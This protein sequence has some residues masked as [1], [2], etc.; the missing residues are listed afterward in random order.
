MAPT[1][2]TPD[3]SL[4]RRQMLTSLGLGAASAA[5]ITTSFSP[6]AAAQSRPTSQPV[7]DASAT[8][9]DP[10]TS[11]YVLPKLAYG[12]ADLEPHIDA[13]TMELHHSK[14]HAGYVRGLNAALAALTE[15]RDGRRETSEVKRW[16]RQLA[17]H[18]SGHFL[19]VA[20]WRCMSPN[21][22]G[23]PGGDIGRQIRRDFGTFDRFAAHFKA[24]AGSVEGSGWGILAVEPIS[25]QLMV[26]QAEKHQN[27][28]A[29]GVI[30]LIAVDVWEHAYYLKYQNRRKAYVDAFMNV[31]NWDHAD[32][33]M[34]AI[35]TATGH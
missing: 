30:P 10:N 20:F 3:S 12:Y 29:W 5:A 9:W 26:M 32:A 22:G 34:T 14:H 4:D 16:S 19:H 13:A 15:I 27:L 35:H 23:E 11:E 7:M 25:G 8:G 31:I 2:K 18:G 21:G 28:T 17:F 33:M 6:T 24:A 1:P